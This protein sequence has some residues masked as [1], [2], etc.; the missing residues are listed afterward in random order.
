MR[1]AGVAL[2]IPMAALLAAGEPS[3]IVET[4]LNSAQRLLQPGVG[5]GMFGVLVRGE[6]LVV[7]A[8]DDPGIFGVDLVDELD[9]VQHSAALDDEARRELVASSWRQRSEVVSGRE[10][11]P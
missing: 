3:R 10:R 9:W 6:E 7:V 4:A 2:T 8:S 5:A 1:T 11:A